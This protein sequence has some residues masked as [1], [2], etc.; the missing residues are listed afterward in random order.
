MKE[1]SSYGVTFR[2]LRQLLKGNYHHHI[3]K[4]TRAELDQLWQEYLHAITDSM[5]RYRFIQIMELIDQFHFFEGVSNIP[6]YKHET[7][8]DKKRSAKQLSVLIKENEEAEEAFVYTVQK[9][10]FIQRD[11]HFSNNRIVNIQIPKDVDPRYRCAVLNFGKLLLIIAKHIDCTLRE[12][13]V[14]GKMV[15]SHDS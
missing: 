1:G 12:D 4:G 14:L 8:I 13:Q 7:V 5:T 10:G 15:E 6:V 3:L 11:Y 9:R 2:M